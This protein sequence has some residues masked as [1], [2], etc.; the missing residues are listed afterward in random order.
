M[1]LKPD[2]LSFEAAAAIPTSAVTAWK[3]LHD[4]GGVVQGQ[5]VLIIGA[6]GGVG[7]FAIQ[8]AKAA[9]AEV[10][11]VCGP[12]GLELVRSLG[13]DHVVDY[14]RE[15]ISTRSDF[16]LIVDIGGGRT[17][18]RL[19]QALTPQGTLILVGSEKVDGGL[20]RWVGCWPHP[21]SRPF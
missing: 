9:G 1:L 6:S 14:R 19:R 20:A 3:G 2:R 5:Q 12:H 4:V 10:T 7:S 17:L 21:F 8:I 16:D 15:E 13:A 18:S 11:A